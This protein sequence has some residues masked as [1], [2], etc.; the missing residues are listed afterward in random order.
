[1]CYSVAQAQTDSIYTYQ[2]ENPTTMEKT[3]FASKS[4]ICFNYLDTAGFT[5]TP[6]IDSYGKIQNILVKFF[7]IGNCNENDRLYILFEDGIILTAIG[8]NKFAC[9]QISYLSFDA[10]MQIK[11][12]TV[13]IKTIMFSNGFSNEDFFTSEIH[14][15]YFIQLYKSLE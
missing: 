1:M 9:K 4:M 14:S 8:W 13:P 15:R 3:T 7:N 2:A 5:I 11:L 12:K 10:E 6:S